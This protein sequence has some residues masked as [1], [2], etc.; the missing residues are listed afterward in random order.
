[1]TSNIT[2]CT[3]CSSRLTL[4]S[5]RPRYLGTASGKRVSTVRVETRR[6]SR[7]RR[8]GREVSMMNQEPTSQQSHEERMA[9]MA[10]GSPV[11]L[12]DL[13][14]EAYPFDMVQH[15]LDQAAYF[16][17]F[18]IP[19][20]QPSGAAIIGAEGS[21]SLIGVRVS[22]TLHRFDINLRPPS[23]EAGVR[24]VNTVGETAGRLDS[25]WMIAPWDFEALPGR[26]PPP[27]PADPSRS[28]RFVMLDGICKFGRGEDGFYGFGTGLT[29]PIT[30]KGRTQLL[31]AAVGNIMEGFG[32]LKGREGSYTCSGALAPERGFSGNLICRVIDPEGSLCLDRELP[33]LR[34]IPDPEPGITYLLFRGQKKDRSQKTTYTFGPDGRLEGFRVEQ[35]LKLF[36]LDFAARGREGLRSVKSIGQVIGKM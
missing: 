29:F 12:P 34:P 33:G 8:R 19:D 9:A 10:S 6:K 21:G 2:T 16:N 22:G 3:G 24:A 4:M 17:M 20:P 26:E 35:Q 7:A 14:A 1:M 27:T 23:I 13:N 36:H 25:R 18:L 28:Q 15:L 30:V 11:S 31:A 32:K 5:A